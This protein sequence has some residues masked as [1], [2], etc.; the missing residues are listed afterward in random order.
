[1]AT[2]GSLG[3][4]DTGEIGTLERRWRHI[5]THLD[6]HVARIDALGSPSLSVH[7]WHLFQ[8]AIQ[9]GNEGIREANGIVSF[10]LRHFFEA[11][12]EA[13]GD[14]FT[15]LRSEPPLQRSALRRYSELYDLAARAGGGRR[16]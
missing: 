3:T 16:A 2:G 7:H 12:K 14:F 6:L 10:G 13:A 4:G 11:L 1:M 5:A 8:V 9:P 15:K